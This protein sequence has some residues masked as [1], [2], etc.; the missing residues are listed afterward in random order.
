LSAAAGEKEMVDAALRYSGTFGGAKL[1]A[2]VAWSNPGDSKD[3]SQINGSAS[4]LLPLG[5][6]FTIAGGS[7]DL[8]AMPANGDDPTFMYGKI[9]WK[10]DQLLSC[11]STALSVDYGRYENIKHQ[12]K[13]EEGTAYGLQLVQKLADWNTELFAAYRSF[14]LEDDTGA[15]YDDISLVMGGARLKF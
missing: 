11:G 6:N 4:L 2:A 10:F 14:E 12:D 5:L 3:Y 9:G 1:K 13:G 8:D 15:A 7:R